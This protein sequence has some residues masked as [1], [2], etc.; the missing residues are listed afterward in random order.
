M[1]TLSY[2]YIASIWWHFRIYVY[3]DSFCIYTLWW[4]PR[5][6]TPR[7]QDKRIV[8]K[9]FIFSRQWYFFPLWFRGS[10]EIF[11]AIFLSQHIVVASICRVAQPRTNWPNKNAANIMS[12]FMR[13]HG[14][15]DRL[16]SSTHR[17]THIGITEYKTHEQ[18][19]R[20]TVT[21]RLICTTAH[22]LEW[23]DHKRRPT[24]YY[25]ECWVRGAGHSPP[26]S[27]VHG[28]VHFLPSSWVG[29]AGHFLP[30][31]FQTVYQHSSLPCSWIIRRSC[32]Y[33]PNI[34]VRL[35]SHARIKRIKDTLGKQSMF[36]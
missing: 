2:L 14:R 1:V 6:F 30:S 8:T 25:E 3:G 31:A 5:L 13:F 12:G 28:A 10:F 11:P 33:R 15:L 7:C 29:D 34:S 24:I 35:C 32:S 16:D 26:S 36:R 18:T 23:T 9:D 21:H 20:L 22:A 19:H 4:R 27:W 17:Q